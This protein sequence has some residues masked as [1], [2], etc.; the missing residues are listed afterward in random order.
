MDVMVKPDGEARFILACP[1]QMEWNARVDLVQAVRD[2]VAGQDFRGI[3]LD[4]EKVSYVNSAGLGAIFS[5]RKH[6]LEAGAS[7]V[8]ARA[9]ATILRLLKTVNLSALMPVVETLDEARLHLNQ[10]PL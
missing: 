10:G 6:V 9:N 4:L 5:L 7:I 1:R 2:G 8:I 3:I